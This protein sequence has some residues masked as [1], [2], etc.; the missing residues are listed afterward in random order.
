MADVLHVDDDDNV[1]IGATKPGTKRS[2]E[3]LA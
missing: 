1:D 3:R 2:P